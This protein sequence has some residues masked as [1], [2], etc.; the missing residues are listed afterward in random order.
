MTGS[1]RG[2][3]REGPTRVEVAVEFGAASLIGGRRKSPEPE[4][5]MTGYES[6]GGLRDNSFDGWKI[7]LYEAERNKNC[8]LHRSV[9]LSMFK[10]CS[11]E[12]V[13]DL[14]RAHYF[15]LRTPDPRTHMAL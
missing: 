1:A 7:S 9:S 4:L 14:S 13:H 15:I 6:L 8:Q 10:R 11:W 3:E 12:T 2:G 5:L